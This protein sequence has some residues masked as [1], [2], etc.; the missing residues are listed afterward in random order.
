MATQLFAAATNGA[1]LAELGAVL[2]VLA[3]RA[4]ARLANLL[5]VPVSRSTAL[6][7]LRRLPLPE[8]MVPRV[9][10]VDDFALPK[11]HSYGTLLLDP[12]RRQRL[13]LLPDREAATVA[14]E[15]LREAIT[16][17]EESVGST[18]VETP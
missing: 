8:L 2:L 10:G 18:T 3:A 1:L 14:T 5:A 12:E 4:A 17:L 16:A 13:A 7:R 15:R 6:R 9:I 11:R